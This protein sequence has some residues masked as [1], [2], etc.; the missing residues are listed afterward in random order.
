[1]K[2]F[3]EIEDE[4]KR[5]SK[6]LEDAKNQKFSLINIFDKISFI[7]SLYNSLSIGKKLTIKI[8]EISDDYPNFLSNNSPPR[9]I[10]QEDENKIV[11]LT[12]YL[13]KFKDL[14]VEKKENEYFLT[15]TKSSQEPLDLSLKIDHDKTIDLKLLIKDKSLIGVKSCYYIKKEV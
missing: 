14:S 3:K 12:D 15:I 4:K 5:F 8:D 7:E 1:M 2:L 6:L 10:I 11:P 13:K 9:L